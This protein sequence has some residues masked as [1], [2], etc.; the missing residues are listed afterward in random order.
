MFY[1]HMTTADN[2]LIL[3]PNGNLANGSIVNYL[4]LIHIQMCI[5]DRNI[6]DEL[7]ESAD[8]DGANAIQKFIYIT[9]PQLKPKM[10][11]RDRYGQVQLYLKL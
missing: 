9:I 2:K 1:T 10:C 4:S 11:I 3:V 7:Y 8:I 5:R 6:P